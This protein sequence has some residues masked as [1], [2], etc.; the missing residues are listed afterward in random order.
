MQ[1]WL[2]NSQVKLH[3]SGP[4]LVGKWKFFKY[5]NFISPLFNSKWLHVTVKQVLTAHLKIS[6]VLTKLSPLMTTID[7]S[8]QSNTGISE[9]VTIPVASSIRERPLF[10][11]ESVSSV[12]L[13]Y[14]SKTMVFWSAH[15][16]ISCCWCKLIL[17]R[18]PVVLINSVTCTFPQ[19]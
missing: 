11:S 10:L 18:L 6:N 19:H 13:I 5:L 16:L 1:I 9:I 4:N 2:N 7:L 17:P 14:I 15:V 3:Q 12:N 8:H